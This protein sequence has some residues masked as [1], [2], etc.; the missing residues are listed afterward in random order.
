M[1]YGLLDNLKDES[2]DALIAGEV[3]AEHGLVRWI[4][5]SMDGFSDR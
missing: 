1:N 4:F 2:L 3:A 5:G